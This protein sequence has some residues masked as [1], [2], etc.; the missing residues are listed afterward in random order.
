[1]TSS[2][3]RPASPLDTAAAAFAVL[4]CEPWPPLVMD[5]DA[6]TAGAGAGADAGLPAGVLSLSVLR[7]WLR[8]HPHAYA[9]QDVVWRELVHRARLHQG[10]WLIGAVGM[11]VAAL[12]RIASDLCGG[13]GGERDDVDAEVLTGFLQALREYVDDGGTGVCASLV[14][15]AKR[16]GLALVTADGSQVP[17]ADLRPLLDGPQAPH[18]PYGHPDLLVHRAAGLGLIDPEDAQAWLDVRLGGK[19]P[20]PIAADLGVTPDA[21]RMRLAR[22]DTRLAEALDA[23]ALTGVAAAGVSRL[24]PA[25]APQPRTAGS[26]PR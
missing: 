5:C 20:K 8:R 25:D 7:D 21:L 24:N 16:A 14:A 18:R 15:A 2:S 10:E 23:G 1:M 12:K 11:A 3:G 4:T 13:Y 19:S 22:V 17:M 9:A 6:L 26:G